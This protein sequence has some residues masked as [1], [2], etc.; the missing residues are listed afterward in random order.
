MRTAIRSTKKSPTITT[1][2]TVPAATITEA[3][4]AED[5]AAVVVATMAAATLM[6]SPW[7]LSTPV[8]K[9]PATATVP[10]FI[11]LV[12]GVITAAVAATTITTAAMSARDRRI[13]QPV[14]DRRSTI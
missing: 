14:L 9:R 12:G 4:V 3:V 6:R 13:T 8:I 2:I 10:A 5:T 1:T 7:S 11:T